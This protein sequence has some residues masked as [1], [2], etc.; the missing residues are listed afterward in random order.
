MPPTD[1]I[2]HIALTVTD[3][4]Q[5]VHWYQTSF[6]CEVVL[7][8]KKQAIL[9]FSNVKLSLV[10]PSFQQNHL[11]YVRSDAN[12]LGELREQADGTLSTFISD[13]SGNL[14]EIVDEESTKKQMSPSCE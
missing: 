13:S 1:A 7:R 8:D 14:V 10:L 2:H 12:T 11:A 4:D 6:R 3:L 5:A 9:Q